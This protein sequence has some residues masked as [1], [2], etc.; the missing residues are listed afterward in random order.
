M[1]KKAVTFSH[2]V[3]TGFTHA[4]V[5]Y[6]PQ[7]CH[8]ACPGVPW[9]RSYPG[10]PE[11]EIRGSVAEGPA[12]SLRPHANADK[13]STKPATILVETHALPYNQRTTCT[14]LNLIVSTWV[15]L[16]AAAYVLIQ[17]FDGVKR[18]VLMLLA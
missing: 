14:K 9:D 13:Q 15:K 11:Q 1:T 16:I 5:G 8:P 6:R 10:F 7:L 2:R 18:E 4:K 17:G 3:F 12:V